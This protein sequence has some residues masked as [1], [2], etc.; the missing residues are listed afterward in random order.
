[1]TIGHGT[2]ATSHGLHDPVVHWYQYPKVDLVST[3]LGSYSSEGTTT[4]KNAKMS[5]FDKIF[6]ESK[7]QDR[8]NAGLL[9]YL[10]S[11]VKP[12]GS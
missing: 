3:A 4:R 1:M 5:D 11:T 8:R 12:E 9:D 6:G 2:E 7:L 10:L